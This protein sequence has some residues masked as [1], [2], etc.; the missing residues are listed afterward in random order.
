VVNRLPFL[1]AKNK[2][3]VKSMKQW[4]IDA[5]IRAI[6]T[7]AQ[8]A[9]GAISGAAIF[10]DVDWLMVLSASAIAGITSLLMSVGSLPTST[11]EK[12]G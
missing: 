8:T 3:K 1:Y 4:F 11:T 6:K 5:G 7:M 12:E 10:T 9:V 2:R